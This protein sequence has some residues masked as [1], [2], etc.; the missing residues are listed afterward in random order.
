MKTSAARVICGFMNA[1]INIIHLSV[2]SIIPVLKG[3]YC[4]RRGESTPSVSTIVREEFI[5][6]QYGGAK[7]RQDTVPRLNLARHPTATPKSLRLFGDPRALLEGDD[8]PF[9]HPWRLGLS[10]P[11][12]ALCPACS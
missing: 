1:S 9:S 3:T 2:D 6:I 12:T 7:S 11:A 4:W 8:S 5:S 10:T